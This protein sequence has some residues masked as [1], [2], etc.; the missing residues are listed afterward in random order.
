M[1][2]AP[3]RIGYYCERTVD[4][5]FGEPFNT[6][7]NLAFL[8]AAWLAFALWRKARKPAREP[9]FLIATVAAI[10]IGSFAFHAAPSRTT[11]LMDVVPIQIFILGYL[12]VVLRRVVGLSL[13]LAVAC[14]V[15][16]VVASQVAIMT[17]GASA[18]GGGIGYVPAL[19]LLI[20]LGLAFQMSNQDK[21]RLFGN[22]LLLAGGVFV[23]SLTART[24]DVPLCG[25]WPMGLHGFWHLLNALVL[26]VL[27][28]A[29]IRH[30]SVNLASDQ[31]ADAALR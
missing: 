7:T 29:I 20:A 21:M 4:G 8:L 9:L 26:F 27:L 18:L 23:V 14:V 28:R 5:I 3:F 30:A 6:L 19:V 15:G 22:N 2:N 12:L 1:P 25:N 31:S 17:A 11:L 16:F 13:I 10:G 24:A